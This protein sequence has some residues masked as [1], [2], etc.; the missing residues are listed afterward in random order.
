MRTCLL[1]TSHNLKDIDVTIP[2]AKM[3]VITGVSGSG[4]RDVYKRQ[5]LDADKE[6]FLRSGRSLIQ[7]IGRAA[8]NVEG[9]VIMYADTVTPSMQTALEETNRRRT[10]QMEYNRK[11]NITPESIKKACLLY[12]SHEQLSAG[13]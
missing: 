9:R 5:I 2:L 8:R 3:V 13:L 1:Y 4:K 11:H 7:T 12:T 6:G 10:K